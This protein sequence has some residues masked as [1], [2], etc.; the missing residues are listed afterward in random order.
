MCFGL[1]SLI[2]P[3]QHLRISVY[4]TAFQNQFLFRIIFKNGVSAPLIG[5]R[6]RGG[7]RC[8]GGWRRSR[9]RVL[10]SLSAPSRPA[11]RGGVEGSPDPPAGLAPQ[12][13]AQE[14]QPPDPRRGVVPHGAAVE[15]HPQLEP[16]LHLCTGAQTQGG[17]VKVGSVPGESTCR[18][19]GPRCPQLY[20]L[21]GEGRLVCMNVNDSIV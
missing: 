9:G 8:D 20:L 21:I 4:V 6:R 7:S 17:G 13:A 16:R 11:G 3:L 15:L 19:G 12:G 14:T 1:E 5:R 2:Q 10:C 18:H